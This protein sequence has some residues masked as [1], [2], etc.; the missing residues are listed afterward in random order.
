[1]L[2]A[3]TDAES[4]PESLVG[5][6]PFRNWESAVDNGFALRTWPG[7]DGAPTAMTVFLNSLQYAQR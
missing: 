6:G 5:S 2:T 3:E 4:E 1:M 7:G